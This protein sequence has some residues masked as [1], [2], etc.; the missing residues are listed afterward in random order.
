MARNITG[1]DLIQK[2]D[3]TGITL[4]DTAWSLGIMV[5][6]G[7]SSLKA[8][9]KIGPDNNTSLARG[10]IIYSNGTGPYK[11][12]VYFSDT[13]NNYEGSETHVIDTWYR[14]MV[15]RAVGGANT[16]NVDGSQTFNGSPGPTP[17]ALSAGDALSIGYGNTAAGI[18]HT[19]DMDVERVWFLQGTVL[20]A[21]AGDAVFDDFPT[22]L[23]TYGADLKLLS[24][25]IG[26]SSPEDDLSSS[27]NDLTCTGTT[28]VADATGYESPDGGGG[29]PTAPSSVTGHSPS[30]GVG[31][32]VATQ[33]ASGETPTGIQF[34][35]AP[36]NSGAPGTPVEDGSPETPPGAGLTVEHVYAAF[37]EG[38]VR[39]FG[40]YATNASGDSTT[41]WTAAAITIHSTPAVSIT[42]PPGTGYAVPAG[43]TMAAAATATD[44]EDGTLTASVA[45][46]DSV[47]GALHT[48]GASWTLD[49]T[50]WTAGAHVVTAAVT[51]SDGDTGSDSFTLTIGTGG[52][53]PGDRARAQYAQLGGF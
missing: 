18:D 42:A 5:R 43:A 22:A 2:V 23:A 47:E 44:A 17:G 34:V 48:G 30:A 20:S 49:T 51:D 32:A 11:F 31:H 14:L 29:A 8:V 7:S 4:G 50:G 40:A 28:K 52:A 12:G 3:P 38:A 41:T 37:A 10:F 35:Y 36:D 21:A 15:T 53:S 26:D 24:Y 19:A 1:T 6:I 45:W 13:T 16:I 9:V 33:A 25:I 46:T 27:A 39:W